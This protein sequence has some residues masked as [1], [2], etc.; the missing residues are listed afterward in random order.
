MT[1]FAHAAAV[2]ARMQQSPLPQRVDRGGDRGY[3]GLASRRSTRSPRNASPDIA[4]RSARTIRSI[5][6][7]REVGRFK[8]GQRVGSQLLSAAQLSRAPQDVGTPRDDGRSFALPS[9]DGGTELCSACQNDADHIWKRHRPSQRRRSGTVRYSLR[10]PLNRYAMAKV[11]RVARA[12]A[13][14][15]SFPCSASNVLHCPWLENRSLPR[16][17]LP[18]RDRT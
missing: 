3:G 2:P 16:S 12:F 7:F 15:Q 6:P 1:S 4:F 17:D 5:T 13:P 18:S 14:T 11:S 10:K 8:D 9:R